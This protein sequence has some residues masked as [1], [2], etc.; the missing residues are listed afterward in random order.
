[1]GWAGGCEARTK[2]VTRSIALAVIAHISGRKRDG[3]A[4]RRAAG[5]RDGQ[6]KDEQILHRSINAGSF[7][8]VPSVSRRR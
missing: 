4:C 6:Q 7:M 5:H 8:K 1:M 2:L 3:Y